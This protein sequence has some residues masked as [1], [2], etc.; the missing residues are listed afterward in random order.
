VWEL[1]DGFTYMEHTQACVRDDGSVV[2]FNVDNGCDYFSNGFEVMVV[3][4]QGDI[5]NQWVFSDME[6]SPLVPDYVLRTT[7]ANQNTLAIGSIQ[8]LQLFDLT[9]GNLGPVISV[10]PDLEPLE[11]VPMDQERLV[12]YN[13]LKA[14]VIN[15]MSSTINSFNFVQPIQ[16]LSLHGDAFYAIENMGIR[17]YALDGE[18][19]GL[20]A[21]NEGSFIGHSTWNSNV[22]M[23]VVAHPAALKEAK[24]FSETLNELGSFEIV[25]SHLFDITTFENG[26]DQYWIGGIN[27]TEDNSGW[28]A[29][30]KSYPF[31]SDPFTTQ[32]DIG[33]TD[34]QFGNLRFIQTQG[35]PPPNIR[36]VLVGDVEVYLT[37]FSESVVQDWSVHFNLPMSFPP[38]FCSSAVSFRSGNTTI[39]V[40]QTISTLLLNVPLAYAYNLEDQEVTNFSFCI[41]SL[42]PNNLLDDYPD[43]DSY[44]QEGSALFTTVKDIEG[45]DFSYLI[46]EESV[47]LTCNEAFQYVLVDM[48]GRVI[49][50]GKKSKGI[51]SISAESLSSGVYAL[52]IWNAQFLKTIRFSK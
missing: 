35:A 50:L 20:F 30:L 11:I 5:I 21:L 13:P 23:A 16:K 34:I 9:T 12:F 44:C 33:V 3:S 48:Q 40:G 38:P 46:L 47:Q 49:D 4:A 17:K 8:G 52:T 6:N 41:S 1:S 26:G 37:N 18:L 25:D 43:N 31:N 36:Y 45:I 22:L 19:L 10:D 7:L 24:I 51:N 28:R 27:R 29:V 32:E 39:E 14:V 15:W 42:G 2:I